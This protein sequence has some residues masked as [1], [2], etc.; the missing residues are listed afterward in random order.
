MQ[1][2]K[3]H[4]KTTRYLTSKK[5]RTH[6]ISTLVSNLSKSIPIQTGFITKNRKRTFFDLQ[7]HEILTFLT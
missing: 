4:N 2:Y 6:L 1:Q 5:N 3:T 7:A